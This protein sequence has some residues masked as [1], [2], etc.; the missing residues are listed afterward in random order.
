[1]GREHPPET[2]FRAQE[3][4]CVDRMTFDQVAKAVGVSASTVKAW[5]AKH[6]WPVKRAEIAQAESDMR[7][8]MVIGRSRMIRKM[9]DTQD[10]QS[11]YAVA[12]LEGLAMKRAEHLRRGRN[13]DEAQAASVR[14]VDL[15]DPTAVAEA[16]REAVR[17]RLARQVRDGVDLAG[18]KEILQALDLIT[19]LEPKSGD[20]D[21]PERRALAVASA[22][23]IRDVLSGEDA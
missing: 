15:A 12:S 21:T 2:V 14:E 3:L 17:R 19:R 10:P 8:D 1:M 22:D 9:M 20:G 23:L 13:L 5:S 7:A 6:G 16:L 18:V 4:Y 11:A